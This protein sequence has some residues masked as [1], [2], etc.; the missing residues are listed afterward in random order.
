MIYLPFVAWHRR[1]PLWHRFPENMRG[2]FH[3]LHRTIMDSE[4]S[5]IWLVLGDK[6]QRRAWK[7]KF[8]SNS[9]PF[10]PQLKLQ[11]IDPPSPV[12]MECTLLW[13]WRNEFYGLWQIS[14]HY[15]LDAGRDQ[16]NLPRLQVMRVGA[17]QRSCRSD[18]F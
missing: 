10:H 18:V 3:K 7:S 16:H 15:C 8:K 17:D 14:T 2:G 12:F 11:F 13:L 4:S 5:L 1:G 9:G 6:R